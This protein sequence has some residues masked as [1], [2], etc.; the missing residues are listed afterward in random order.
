MKGNGRPPYPLVQY[1]DAKGQLYVAEDTGNGKLA[2]IRLMADG[3][4]SGLDIVLDPS[5]LDPATGRQPVAMSV[6]KDVFFYDMLMWL[7]MAVIGFTAFVTTSRL[8]PLLHPVVFPVTIA[9]VALLSL[10]ANILAATLGPRH[11]TLWARISVVSACAAL[12]LLAVSLR[13]VAPIQYFIVQWAISLSVL[14]YVGRAPTGRVNTVHLT[15][16]LASVATGV[17]LVS[18]LSS[19]LHL[20]IWVAAEIRDWVS[21]LLCALL[22]ALSCVHRYWWI[23]RM[24]GLNEFTVTDG[25]TAWESLYTQPLASFIAYVVSF[26][27][28]T[29]ATTDTTTISFSP[30]P[31]L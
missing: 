13:V 16:L 27:Q 18:A 7:V 25:F 21:V 10:V 6:L 12:I 14:L 20:R 5:L 2:N 24:I 11:P 30:G 1:Q 3:N 29:T 23:L 15:R 19:D 26:R 31:E 8:T 9:V 28:V 4:E 17:W 22:A